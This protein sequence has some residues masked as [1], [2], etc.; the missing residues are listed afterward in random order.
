MNFI[1]GVDNFG[2]VIQEG[3]NFIDKSLFIKEILDNSNTKATVITRPRRFGKTLNMSMLH[4]F[5]AEKVGDL[6]TKGMFDHLKIAQTDAA[7]MGHQ[8]KYPVIFI[9]FKRMACNS[10]DETKQRFGDL[11]SQLYGQHYALLSKNILRPHEKATFERIL[12]QQASDMN[13]MS[14]LRDLSGYLHRYHGTKPWIL[15][16]EYDTPIQAGYTNNHYKEVVEFMRGILGEALKGNDDM[17]RA[18]IT[19]ILQI[20]KESLFSGLNNLKASSLLSDEYAEHFGFTETEVDKALKKANI[21]HLANEIKAWYNG[22]HIGNHQIYNPWSIVNCISEKGALKPYWVNTANSDLIKTSIASTDA[23]EKEQFE[24][25]LAGE[26][27]EAT[28]TEKMAFGDLKTN[29]DALWNL[30]LFSGYL[31]NIKTDLV[32]GEYKCLLQTPNQ[33][34]ATVYR[35]VISGWFTAPLGE[36]RYRFFLKSLT[37]G[38]LE[39]FLAELQKFLKQSSSYFDA[40]GENPEKFYHGFVLGLIVGLSDT[41]VVQSNKES[42]YGRYDVMII[43][44]DTQQLGLVLEFKVA[45]PNKTM[46]ETAEEALEQIERRS[47]ET[48]LRQKGIQHILKIG[49]GF[50]GKKV[51]MAFSN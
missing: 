28:I 17:H 20:S 34:I 44:K 12:N 51:A 13:L 50:Q 43:P 8:G 41:H 36:I 35:T 27:I 45:K 4:H 7:Y 9:S 48:E 15:I 37:S 33:E 49:L 6:E 39:M 30:L 21:G 24:K 25:I 5:L 40:S 16:D 42:G 14:S 29:S 3:L 10:Y 47:Y 18:V 19:G 23:I 46:Q 11:L 26:S 38:D 1:I 22:Y 2:E 32:M 31:T